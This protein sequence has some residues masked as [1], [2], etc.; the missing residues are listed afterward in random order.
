MRAAMK[1]TAA[2]AL[3]VALCLAASASGATADVS[4]DT[5]REVAPSGKLR[6]AIEYG[7]PVVVARGWRTKELRGVAVEMA[8][9]LGRELGVPVELVGYETRAKLLE[10]LKADAWDVGFLAMDRGPGGE[11]LFAAPYMEVELTYLVRARWRVRAIA[12]VDASGV[13][14]AVQEQSAAD[15]FLTEA[16]R[17]AVLFRTPGD[18]EALRLLEVDAVEAFAANTQRLLS[19]AAKNPDYRVLEGHFA[20]IEHGAAVPAGRTASAQY[21]RDS[22]EHLKASG[23]VQRAIEN[24]GL[25]G[26]AVAPPR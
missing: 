23:F 12:D 14:V 21:V 13:R 20:V 17:H 8:Y 15:L 16:L 18:Q 19:I 3:L 24:A 4:A 26:V 5:R 7:N 6:A 10:G 2:K 22:I 1:R 25:H 9:E 11:I